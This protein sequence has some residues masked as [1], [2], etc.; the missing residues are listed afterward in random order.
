[1]LTLFRDELTAQKMFNLR[2]VKKSAFA[3]IGIREGEPHGSG[4][5]ELY[6]ETNLDVTNLTNS[7][8]LPLRQLRDSGFKATNPQQRKV[9][10][11]VK[12]TYVKGQLFNSSQDI[13]AGY[14][15]DTSDDEETTKQKPIQHPASIRL[16]P[17]QIPP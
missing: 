3:N 1:M 9:I 17:S 2:R 12:K 7:V 16:Q 4:T 15:A 14:L 10:D 8:R 13:E 5:I 11:T 6:D